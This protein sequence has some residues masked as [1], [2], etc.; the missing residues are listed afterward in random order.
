VFQGSEQHHNH[1]NL[2]VQGA[3]ATAEAQQLVSRKGP[4]AAIVSDMGRVGDRQAGY[5]FLER[6]RKDGIDTPYFIYTTSGL[7]A[8]LGPVTRLRG[9]QG[10][11]A[12][13]DALVQ[14]VLAAIR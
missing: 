3:R 14:M 11:T 7:A 1:S 4:F 9:A 5:T 13:P 2:C 8:T 10:I 12:D 6:V